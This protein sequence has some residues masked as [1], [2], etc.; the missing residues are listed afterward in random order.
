MLEPV[1]CFMHLLNTICYH[2]HSQY[3]LMGLHVGAWNKIQLSSASYKGSYQSE[4]FLLA[5]FSPRRSP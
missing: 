1:I 2:R 3:L 5:V 4:A